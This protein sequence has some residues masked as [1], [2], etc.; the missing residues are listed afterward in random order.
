MY[1]VPVE[2]VEKIRRTRKNVK[3]VLSDLGLE[4]CLSL[5]EDLRSFDA[6]DSVFSNTEWSDL[7]EGFKNRGR[8]KWLY[9]TQ[10]V[11]C[12]LCSFS[13]R[14]WNSFRTHIYRYHEDEKKWA[15]LSTCSSCP[16][17]A[18]PKVLCRHNS[19]FHSE[20]INLPSDGSY[21]GVLSEASIP[22]HN[23]YVCQK[24]SYEGALLFNVKKHVLVKHCANLLNEFVSQ[25]SDDE[26]KSQGLWCRFYCK[27]CSMTA[28]TTEHLVYHFLTSEKHSNVQAHVQ[29]LI[30]Q[31][32]KHQKAY[33]LLA[34][35]AHLNVVQSNG[36][37]L[38]PTSDHQSLRV[39]F[40]PD[41]VLHG[42]SSSNLICGSGPSQTLL[43][44]QAAALVQLASAEA[45]GLL[46]PDSSA[47]LP[48]PQAAK[49]LTDTMPSVSNMASALV[50]AQTLPSLQPSVTAKQLPVA[51]GL[52]GPPPQQVLLPPGLQ[53]NI[54]G[55]RVSGPQPLLLTQ[56]LP[57][58]QPVPRGTMLTS[59]SLLSHLIPTGNKVN[60]LPTYTLAPVQVAMPVQSG[61]N[62]VMNRTALP[63]SQNNP[64]NGSSTESGK[65]KKWI[66]CP[67]CSE[68]FPTS[69]YPLHAEIHQGANKSKIGLAARA[70]FLRKM[71]DKTV[72]CLI[73]KV[74]LSEKGLFDHLLHGVT[75]L[76]CPTIFH[77]IKQLNDHISSQHFP[78]KKENFDFMRREYRLYTDEHGSLL[79]PY[80]DINTTGPRDM[81][82]DKELNVALVTNSL[83]LIFVKLLPSGPKPVCQTAVNSNRKVCP[84]CAES[85][86]SSEDYRMHLRQSHYIVPTVHAILKTPAYKCV[87]CG[88][89]YTG[90][91]TAKAIA[92][93][94]ERCKCAP[95]PL[96]DPQRATPAAPARQVVAPIKPVNRDQGVF[97]MQPLQAVTKT[98]VFTAAPKAQPTEAELQSKLRL[99]L[100]VK[101]AM[102]ANR[103]E[104]EARAARKRLEKEMLTSCVSP[105]VYIDPTVVFALDPSGVEKQPFE[106]RRDFL[107]RYFHV[108]PYLTKKEVNALAGRLLLTKSDVACHFGTRRSKCMRSI[109]RNTAKVLLGFN[110]TEAMKLKHNLLIPE[111]EP[112]KP[113]DVVE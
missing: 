13:T 41:T 57:L 8:K 74:L 31:K 1:Q 83:D 92:V 48:G 60:G 99:E 25:R 53:V 17:I 108:K 71:P 19:I 4:E 111:V 51:V 23:K 64:V 77:S 67:L 2:S 47:T 61:S 85:L 21:S 45:R 27:V 55:P 56:R 110:M 24:C 95:K 37:I 35:K 33:P 52:P 93:H 103:R 112:E 102:E 58:N 14:S 11:C 76:F 86:P 94:V 63:A 62:P 29:S 80:F 109:Q 70:S 65:T 96:K 78:L 88:G 22:S 79:F 98:P 42:M 66:T 16:F 18:H 43:P 75:C 6:G 30:W 26:V 49:L 107:N 39:P 89:V 90:K 36:P 59:Q 40:L 54:P 32:V 100:A 84:F 87:Y 69:V 97:A 12:S 28:E 15:V 101:E 105:E 44:A 82:G 73:C 113:V 34:P 72:K 9:R 91:T 20:A 7:T 5:I 10:P 3:N 50:K 38:A 81:L 68:L 106:E 46:R 104:R